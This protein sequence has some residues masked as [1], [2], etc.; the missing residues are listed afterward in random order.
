V[1]EQH[2]ELIRM[3]NEFLAASAAGKGKDDLGKMIK[4]LGDYAVKHF[5]HEEQVMAKHNCPFAKQNKE[6]HAAFLKD[7]TG[8]SAKFMTEGPSLSFVME[9]QTKVLTWLNGH[10]RGCDA[11]LRQCVS[12]KAA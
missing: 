5:A 3:L 10:I 9:V 11:K 4:Y 6:A 7:F 12:T 1:D 2:K 8:L